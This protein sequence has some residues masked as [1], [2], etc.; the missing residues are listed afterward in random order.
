MKNQTDRLKNLDRYALLIFLGALALRFLYL[1]QIQDSPFLK[2]PQIDA[3]WHHLWSKSIASGNILGDE[4]FF[5]APLYPYFLGLIYSIFG[6][7][8]IAPRIIQSILGSISCVLIY[9]IALRLFN[10]RTAL[11]AGIIAA[12]YSVLIYFDNELLITSLFVFLVLLIFYLAIDT[13]ISSSKKRLYLIGLVL[14]LAAIARPTILIILPILAV[15]LFFYRVKPTR[16]KNKLIGMVILFAGILTAILPVTIRNYAVG[17]D[18]VL[19]SYQGGVNFWIGNNEQADGKTAGAPG[20][21]KAVGRYEDNVKYSAEKVAEMDTGREMKPSELSSYWYS[22]GFK[23]I[24]ENPGEFMALTLKKLYF[25]WN[26]YEIESNRN[27]YT[28]REHSS[29]LRILLWHNV[30]GFPFG[31]LAPLAIAGIVLAFRNWKRTYLLLIGFLFSYQL[32]LLAFFVTA[33]FRVPMLPFIIILAAMALDYAVRNRRQL[34]KLIAPVIVF[35]ISIVVCNTTLF[36]VRPAEESRTIQSKAS[37]FLRQGQVDSAIVYA[38]KAIEEN[39]EDPAGYDFLG[40][41]Y[42]MA[43]EHQKAAAVFE[44]A[45]DLNSQNAYAYYHLGYNYYQLGQLEKA[46]IQCRQALHID[47]TVVDAYTYLGN[48]YRDLGNQG[49]ALDI[50]ERGTRYA[51]ENIRFLNSYANVLRESGQEQKAIEN[52]EKAVEL[53][54]QYLPSH[55]NLANL[56]FQTGQPMK[57]ES[58]YK[59][60]LEIDPNDIQTN[61]NLAQLYIRTNWPQRAKELI[62]NVLEDHPHHPVANRLMEMVYDMM[63]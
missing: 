63:R 56:Y 12:I 42:E 29:L 4:V 52:L 59:R 54:S 10:R 35:V 33:R 58:M 11:I 50:F 13:Q 39:P 36:G 43:G 60:A 57:A 15:Y 61:L 55:T 16:L 24:F 38:E 45:V 49:L 62:Q 26:A 6:D 23:F 47:S 2:Y 44:K 32:I 51:S 41:A 48:I 20:H 18:I 25:T 30:L 34:S 28:Q 7:G 8:P 40:T 9:L 21:F 53:D 14:G 22:R 27:L 5:R 3:L 1:Y 19:I 31:I 37:I 46:A 17:N